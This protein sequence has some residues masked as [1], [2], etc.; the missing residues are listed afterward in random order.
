MNNQS[1][2][3]KKISSSPS[4]IS[5]INFF[6]QNFLSIH[7]NKQLFIQLKSGSYDQE[8]IRLFDYRFNQK[9]KFIKNLNDDMN[10]NYNNNNNIHIF[11]TSDFLNYYHFYNN[12]VSEPNLLFLVYILITILRSIFLRRESTEQACLFNKNHFFYIIIK[13]KCLK[14]LTF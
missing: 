5:Y 14:I 4:L 8:F 13:C 2:Y 12:Y 7:I 6:I 9:A 3:H 10:D 11:N 1:K